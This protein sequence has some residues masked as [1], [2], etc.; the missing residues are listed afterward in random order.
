[1]QLQASSQLTKA[2]WG[3]SRLC[4]AEPGANLFAGG[5]CQGFVSSPWEEGDFIGFFWMPALSAGSLHFQMW[6][7]SEG[8]GQ[9][10]PG[11]AAWGE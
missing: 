8:P 3:V 1:M 2:T 5:G 6:P 10:G 9:R 7:A 4:R 11:P